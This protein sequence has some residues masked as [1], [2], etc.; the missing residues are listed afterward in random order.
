[1]NNRT[2][3]TLKYI[4]RIVLPALATLYGTLAGIWNLPYGKAIV[5]TISALALFLNALLQVNANSYE[6]D[7]SDNLPR[8]DDDRSDD[9]PNFEEV[10]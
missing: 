8:T 2:Y 5:A 3:D 6:K 10:E 9:A 1:M 4:G 7:L